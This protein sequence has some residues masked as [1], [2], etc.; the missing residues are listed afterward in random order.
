MTKAL[1]LVVIGLKSDVIFGNNVGSAIFV[2]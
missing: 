2:D 1:D